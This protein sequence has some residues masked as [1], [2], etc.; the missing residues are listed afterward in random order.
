VAIAQIYNLCPFAAFHQMSISIW[1]T[2]DATAIPLIQ[3]FP[4]FPTY[5]SFMFGIYN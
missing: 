5:A 1:K 4:G 2:F 3:P